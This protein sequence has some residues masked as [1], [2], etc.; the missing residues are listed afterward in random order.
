M[1]DD[2]SIDHIANANGMINYEIVCAVG[3]CVPKVYKENNNVVTVV[4]SIV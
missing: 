1:S 3:E 4:D 2:V